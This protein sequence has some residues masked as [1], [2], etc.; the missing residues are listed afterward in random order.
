MEEVVFDYCIVSL[1]DIQKF[2]PASIYFSEYFDHS[3]WM[4][5]ISSGW[6]GM[7]DRFMEI[8]DVLFDASSTVPVESKGKILKILV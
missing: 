1:M 4:K 5:I 7:I 6:D 2:Q 8:Y 3:A